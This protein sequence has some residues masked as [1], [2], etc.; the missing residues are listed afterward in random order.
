[1]MLPVD[2]IVEVVGQA[3][4]IL[5]DDASRGGAVVE[6]IPYVPSEVVMDFPKIVLGSAACVLAYAW[7]AFEFGSVSMEQSVLVVYSQCTVQTAQQ[8]INSTIQQR[9]TI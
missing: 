6:Q 5:A 7:A 2:G 8:S 1:M 3:T 4:Y 9:S